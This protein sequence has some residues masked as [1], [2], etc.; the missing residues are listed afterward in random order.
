[1]W[2][3]LYKPRRKRQKVKTRNA[4]TCL[5][6]ISCMFE[7]TLLDPHL[8][9]S[10]M[11]SRIRSRSQHYDYLGFQPISDSTSIFRIPRRIFNEPQFGTS[12]L[13]VPMGYGYPNY[14]YFN[15]IRDSQIRSLGPN[16]T[17]IDWERLEVLQ[18][19]RSPR[20]SYCH[21]RPWINQK[22]LIFLFSSYNGCF[23]S[24]D[25]IYVY[26]AIPSWHSLSIH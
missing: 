11:I 6:I 15:F 18:A 3:R 7:L 10:L 24:I 4:G 1:M 12:P 2:F 16:F 19:A 23:V 26:S 8:L 22:T 25:D 14:L 20:P 21:Q 13:L 5:S 17:S 9:P